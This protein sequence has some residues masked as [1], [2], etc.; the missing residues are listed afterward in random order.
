MKSASVCEYSFF[1]TGATSVGVSFS[2]L[3]CFGLLCF[4]SAGYY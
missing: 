4:C 3:S 2:E 1:F